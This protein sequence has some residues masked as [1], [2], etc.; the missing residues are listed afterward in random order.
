MLYQA[1]FE[2]K[3]GIRKFFPKKIRLN[4]GIIQTYSVASN[5]EQ[6]QSHSGEI[7]KAFILNINEVM[8]LI[9]ELN[10][11]LTEFNSH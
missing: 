11:T 8:K 6:K 4:S 1:V 2:D 3:Q 7:L 5:I 10:S 9:S